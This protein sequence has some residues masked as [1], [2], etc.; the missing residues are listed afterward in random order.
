M[1]PSAVRQERAG[2]PLAGVK[3][4]SPR[5]DED[6]VRPI[7]KPKTELPVAH[8]DRLIGGS[9]PPN[10]GPKESGLFSHTPSG[11]A[12]GSSPLAPEKNV[13]YPRTELMH[14]D[15]CAARMTTCRAGFERR[16]DA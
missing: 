4:I 3:S 13:L 6:G 16:S 11:A 8:V 2:R 7:T 9:R 1:S 10:S 5:P 12:G 15:A 14:S